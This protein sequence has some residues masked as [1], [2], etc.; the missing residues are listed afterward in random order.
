M[1][2]FNYNGKDYAWRWDSMKTMFLFR[3]RMGVDDVNLI[4][5]KIDWCLSVD[6][7][8]VERIEWIYA[9]AC[10]GFY[11]ANSRD[12]FELE[13]SGGIDAILKDDAAFP[14]MVAEIHL[15]AEMFVTKYPDKKKRMRA[16]AKSLRRAAKRLERQYS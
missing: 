8:S 11:A 4:C 6:G 9:I 16:L 15:H 2:N 13:Q 12:Y 5:N 14:T 3:D 7:D 10:A 1:I